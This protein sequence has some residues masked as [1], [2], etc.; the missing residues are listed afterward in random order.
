VTRPPDQRDKK[1]MSKIIGRAAAPVAVA[2]YFC[3]WIKFKGNR[4][5]KTPSAA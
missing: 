3:I 2:E 5:K 1:K 4:K